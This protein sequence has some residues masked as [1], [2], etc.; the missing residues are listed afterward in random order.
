LGVGRVFIVGKQ[1]KLG[2]WIPNKIALTDADDDLWTGTFGFPRG[3]VVQYKYTVGTNSL[4]GQ[5]AGSEE[6]PFTNRQYVVPDDPATGYV[7]ISDVLGDDPPQ[8]NSLGKFTTVT[9]HEE[10]P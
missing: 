3:E 9:E 1:D 10:T 4:E 8:E 2:D 5:W 7:V 6:F